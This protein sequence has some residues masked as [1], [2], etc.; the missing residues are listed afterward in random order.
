[1]LGLM[2]LSLVDVVFS[3][4]TQVCKATLQLLIAMMGW[5]IKQHDFYFE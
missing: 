2:C 3:E 5:T 1:M 4:G